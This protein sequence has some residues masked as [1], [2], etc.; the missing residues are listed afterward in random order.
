VSASAFHGIQ[1]DGGDI[2]GVLLLDES[3]THFAIAVREQRRSARAR[4]GSVDVAASL[5]V[6]TRKSMSAPAAS[7][8]PA[9]HGS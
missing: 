1:R 8:V 7:W 3:N 9:A 4:D 6:L 2:A 5:L